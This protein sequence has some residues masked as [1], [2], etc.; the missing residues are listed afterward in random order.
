MSDEKVDFDSEDIKP[1]DEKTVMTV[2]GFKRYRKRVTND[3]NHVLF[4]LQK[5]V[6]D[7]QVR[8]NLV[9]NSIN[10]IVRALYNAGLVT[11][12]QLVEA[13]K[14]LMAEHE[15]NMDEVRASHAEQRPMQSENLS[16]TPL[17]HFRDVVMP[18]VRKTEENN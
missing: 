15:K 6:I 18:Q 2:A 14:Q 4:E 9:W 17:E 1:I 10:A 3:L 12:A 8:I 5:G 11:D 7:G 13:G 16:P